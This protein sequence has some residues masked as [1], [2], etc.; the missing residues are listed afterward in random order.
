MKIISSGIFREFLFFSLFLISWETELYPQGTQVAFNTIP[1]SGT[2]LIYAH[3]DDDLIWMLPFWRISEKFIGGNEPATPK[4]ET[5][6]HQ[7]QIYLNNNGYNISYEPNWVTPWGDLTDTQYDR[8]YAD[9][10]PDYQYLALDHLIAY[11]D[12]NDEQLVRKEINRIK[13][14]IEQ[15]FASPSLSRVITHNNWGEYGHQHHKALNKAARELAVKYRK[16]VW[17]LGSWEIYGEFIDVNIPDNITYTSGSFNDPSLYDAIRNIYRANGRWTY[18]YNQVPAGDHKF[19]KIVEGGTDKSNLLTGEE[20]TSSGPYQDEPG[21]YIFDGIDDYLTLQGNNNPSFTISMR[22]RP[23]QIKEM[24]ISCMSEYP[25]SGTFDRNL[26]LT[27]EGHITGRIY[28]GSSRIVTSANQIMADTWSHVALTGDGSSLKLYINGILENTVS[29][30][31]CITNYA[32]PEF[33]LGQATVTGSNFMGQINDVRLYDRVL[34]ASEIAEISGV[35][36]T[37][38]SAA[39]QGGEINPSGVIAVNQG[40]DRTYT[41]EANIGYRVSDLKVDGVSLGAVTTYTFSKI[42]ASHSISA[43]FSPITNTINAASGPGGTISPQGNITLNYGSSQTFSITAGNGYYIS[44]VVVDGTSAG[45][46][47]TYT[48]NNVTARHTISAAFKQFTYSITTSSGAG[49]SINP[50]GIITAN[51]G[52]NR[53]F[54]IIPD[55]GYQISDVTVDNESVGVVSNYTFRNIT[56]DHSI[57]AIFSL[58]TYTITGIAGNGGSISPSGISNVFHGTTRAYTI[59]PDIGYRISEVRV[60]NNSVGPSTSYTF[61]EINSDHT[62]SATFSV[63]TYTLSASTGQGG[64][65]SPQ[66]NQTVNYGTD[67]TFTITP[68]EGFYISDVIVDEVSMGRIS[69]YTFSNITDN[70]SIAASFSHFTYTITGS[71]GPGGYISPPGEIIVNYGDDVTFTFKPEDGFLL[72]DVQVDDVSA[73]MVPTF[74]FKKIVSSH[75]I[76]AT[77]IPIFL[78]VESSS[79]SGGTISSTGPSRVLYGTDLLFSIVPDAGFEIEDVIVDGSSV[80]PVSNYTFSGI[81]SDHTISVFFKVITFEISGSSDTGGS[82]DPSGDVLVTYGSKQTF[83]VT[84]DSGYKI[85]DIKVDG[86]SIGPVFTYSF[87]NVVS[88]H[89]ISATFK[90]MDIYTIIVNTGTGGTIIPSDTIK[91]TEGSCQKFEIIPD[92]GYRIYEVVVDRH[93]AGTT[94]EFSFNDL[95]SNHTISATFSTNRDIDVYP[96]PF[97]DVFN[98]SIATPGEKLFNITISDLSG[99]IIFKQNKIAGNSVTPVH[100]QGSPGFYILRIYCGGTKIA[101]LKIIK[102]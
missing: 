8:Y 102:A 28:D 44:D 76:S 91:L 52:S 92:Y 42:S 62:I 37:I 59:S 10:S 46:I 73:G 9:N 33:V 70:H 85:L 82:I 90:L 96:N 41:V 64:L 34:S 13:S 6:I 80:G 81:T 67:Q 26:Y 29:A 4:Y 53:N 56:E 11:W 25:A 83:T 84:P 75:K 20:V 86:N 71:A 58:V 99:R 17:M 38:T 65:I 93:S 98:L 23:D 54:K 88:T 12:N 32:T 68:L 45:A 14:K 60:D 21:A 79:N 7:Q 74:N 2:A 97:A 24:D 19:I 30:G 18:V 61:T 48:F 89:S 5:I 40:A 50:G 36:Y 43:T 35:D 100:L 66:E 101:S 55:Y 15:Y 39:G 57:S 69:S 22:I 31:T 95:A 51:H 77:F 87:D 94:S 1:K 3:M 49:G 47:S 16:D 63:I 27:S 78:N 72:S